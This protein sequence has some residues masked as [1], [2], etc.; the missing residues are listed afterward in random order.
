MAHNSWDERFEHPA[1][2][3]ASATHRQFTMQAVAVAMAE[4]TYKWMEEKCKSATRAVLG[5]RAREQGL[6]VTPPSAEAKRDRRRAPTEVDA[7]HHA[8]GKALTKYAGMQPRPH[9]GQ[10]PHTERTPAHSR[11]VGLGA[12]TLEKSYIQ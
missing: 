12:P 7:T 11:L 8:D 2:T 6:D 1:K 3:W 9:G 10:H 4:A 5:E